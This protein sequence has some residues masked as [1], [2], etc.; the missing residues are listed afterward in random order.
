MDGMSWLTAIHGG[1]AEAAWSNRCL[2]FENGQDRAVRCGCDKYLLLT[3]GSPEFSTAMTSG[4]PG[5]PNAPPLSGPVE[6]LADLCDNTGSY[7]TADPLRPGVE[8][9]N[10]LANEPAKQVS[11]TSIM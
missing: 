2:F 8:V 1:A 6:A 9:E 11:F 5:W 3:A 7:V 10:T 4:W